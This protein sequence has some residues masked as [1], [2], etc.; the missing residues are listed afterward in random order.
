MATTLYRVRDTKTG[1]FYLRINRW[2]KYGRFFTKNALAQ[3]TLMREKRWM[4]WRPEFEIIEY[5][6]EVDAGESKTKSQVWPL[7]PKKEAPRV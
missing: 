7:K 3:T 6:I 2:G 5:T 1:E 4:M